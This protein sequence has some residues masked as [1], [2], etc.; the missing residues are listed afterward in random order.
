MYKKNSKKLEILIIGKGSIGLRHANIFRDLGCK[1]SFFRTNKSNLKNDFFYKEYFDFKEIRKFSFDLIAICNP[2]SYHIKYLK[3]FQHLSK[4]FLIEKPLC[5]NNKDLSLL[6]KIS[7]SKNIY[8]GY[9]LRHDKRILEIKRRYKNIKK[10]NFTLFKWHTYLPD[11][12]KYENYR[13]SYAAKKKLGGGAIFTCSHEVD[14]AIF[15]FG[16]VKNVICYENKKKLNLEVEESVNI[17][18]KHMNEINSLVSIDFTNKNFIR[19]FK[20]FCK[21]KI[22]KYNF[23]NHNIHEETFGK[24]KIIKIFGNNSIEQIYRI[25][26]ITILKNIKKKIKISLP[27]ETE[28]VLLACHKSLKLKKAVKVI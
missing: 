15:L 11:W 22:I 14:M 28:K 1:V 25:Q 24:K 18:I 3:K 27:L 16:K 19:E 13:N 20:V 17:H 6:K 5:T 26:N 10:I 12:H 7:R 21:N 23:I 9:M 4:N 8:S 2:S